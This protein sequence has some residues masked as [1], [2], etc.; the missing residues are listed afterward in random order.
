MK[1]LCQELVRVT[2]L[3]VA[4]VVCCTVSC[5]PSPRSPRSVLIQKIE[6]PPEYLRENER[7]QFLQSLREGEKIEFEMERISSSRTRGFKTGYYLFKNLTG[8]PLRIPWIEF[9]SEGLAFA[10]EVGF[11]VFRDG[12][13]VNPGYFKDL[14]PIYTEL[15]PEKEIELQIDIPAY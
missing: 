12:K 14:L 1:T 8:H 3:V 11:Q 13:W 5:V 15:E 6:F 2:R 7:P 4:F 9:D 10:D